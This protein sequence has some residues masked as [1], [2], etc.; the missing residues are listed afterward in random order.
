MK[1][2]FDYKETLMRRVTIE[3]KNLGDAISELH[4]K[5]DNENIVLDSSDFAGAE[6]TMP[7][8]ENFIPQLLEYGNEKISKE[9]LDIL[10][11]MW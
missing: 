9:G 8:T 3:S 2:V 11:D 1:F 7:L 5:I 6:I 10:I 4:S